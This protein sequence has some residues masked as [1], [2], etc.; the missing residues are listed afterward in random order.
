[1]YELGCMNYDLNKIV[2][3]HIVLTYDVGA[4]LHDFL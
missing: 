4:G 3:Y 2:S 1:M